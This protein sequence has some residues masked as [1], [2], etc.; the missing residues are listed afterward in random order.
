M[1][2]EETYNQFASALRKYLGS[3]VKDVHH[4]EDLL[5]ATFERIHKNLPLLR[6]TNKLKSWVFSIATNVLRDHWKSQKQWASD[7]LVPE[8]LEEQEE[9]DLSKI[10]QC[11]KVLLEQLPPKYRTAVA[12]VDLEEQSQKEVAAA[13]GLAYSTLKSRVQKGRELLKA[14]LL[15]C[16][17]SNHCNDTKTDCGCND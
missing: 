15:E 14:S 17:K 4:A 7:A 6:E 8:Q 10:S 11:L 1:T 13:Q 12:A 5:Q 16:C 2:T 3:R 9:Y